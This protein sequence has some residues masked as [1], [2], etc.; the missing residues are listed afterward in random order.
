MLL[1]K[2]KSWWFIITLEPGYARRIGQNHAQTFHTGLGSHTGDRSL[3]TAERGRACLDLVCFSVSFSGLKPTRNFLLTFSHID[4]C[5]SP[6]GKNF[7]CRK[8]KLDQNSQKQSE[9]FQ[10]SPLLFCW[11]VCRE[12]LIPWFSNQIIKSAE[13]CA[14]L[15]HEIYR[16]LS[17][18]FWT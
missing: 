16:R 10:T 12:P 4:C 14:C 17:T 2:F 3:S 13:M 18:A 9:R 7:V 11:K 5:K 1:F 8:L 15:F 6:Q